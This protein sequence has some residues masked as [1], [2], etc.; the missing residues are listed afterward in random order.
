MTIS[1]QIKGLYELNGKLTGLP[2]K[3]RT[4]LNKELE[5]FMFDVKKSAKLRVPRDTGELAQSINVTKQGSK[6]VLSVDSPH[7]VY[8]EEG[9]TPHRVYIKNSNKLKDGFY[10][11]KKHK[12]FIS[13]ALETNLNKLSQRISKRVYNIIK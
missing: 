7:G 11:V 1:I 6:Y 8:Q 12:S 13:P 3:M 9:F 2:F 5:S 10:F 4:Q